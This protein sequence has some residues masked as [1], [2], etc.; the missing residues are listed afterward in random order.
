MTFLDQLDIW[1]ILSKFETYTTIISGQNMG[2]KYG[3]SLKKCYAIVIYTLQSN[4]Y[5]QPNDLQHGMLIGVLACLKKVQGEV[6]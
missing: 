1:N 5:L 6:L 4:K 2:S 3:M